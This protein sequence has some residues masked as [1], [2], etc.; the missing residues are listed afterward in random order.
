MGILEHAARSERRHAAAPQRR[1]SRAP[2][3]AEI[4]S[5]DAA[6]TPQGQETAMRRILSGAFG[7]FSGSC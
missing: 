4:R 6:R 5:L 3:G 1:E 7:L 2:A